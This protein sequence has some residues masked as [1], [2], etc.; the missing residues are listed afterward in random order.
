MKRPPVLFTRRCLAVDIGQRRVK[1]MLAERQGERMEVLHAI[2]IDLH[3]EGLL[4][5]E[6]A[7][8]HIARILDK[9][10]DYPVSIV[11]PQQIAPSHLI[12]LAPQ[13]KRGW[14]EMVEEETQ[15]L[16]GLSESALAY[17]VFRLRPFSRHQNPIWVTVSRENDLLSQIAR[18][19]PKLEISE[20]ASAAN[21]LAAAYIATHPPVNRVALVDLGGSSTTIV[22]LDRMQ[23]VFAA[24]LAIGSERFTEALATDLNLSFDEA[25]AVKKTSFL[26]ESSERNDAF[27][28]A[29]EEWRA[30]IE[31]I[32]NEWMRDQA[33]PS[34]RRFPI[35]LTG[36][37]SLQQGLSSHL[38]SVSDFPYIAWNESLGGVDA[39]TYAMVYG[40]ALAG[41]KVSPVSVS[42]LPKDIWA[43]KKRQRQVFAIN[44][45]ACL[46][47][48]GLFA[49]LFMDNAARRR[50]IHEKEGSLAELEHAQVIAGEVNVLIDERAS[51]YNYLEN[52]V[53][54]K[55]RARDLL[56]TLRL[57]SAARQ[58]HE[59]WFLLLADAQSYFY[60][61]TLQQQ[62]LVTVTRGQ[63]TGRRGQAVIGPSPS[64]EI[65]P[66]A[67]Q[68]GTD[69]FIVELAVLDEG[70]GTHVTLRNVVATFSQDPLYRNV[71]TLPHA[72]RRFIVNPN[73]TL[74]GRT[75]ALELNLIPSEMPMPD[76]SPTTVEYPAQ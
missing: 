21:A 43:R 15:K 46:L 40:A 69:S 59:I 57:M 19:D 22:L 29:I 3:E 50:V 7:N 4:T 27:V 26:F 12:P 49:I 33:E 51:E 65:R 39:R 31:R 9:F 75:F 37:G 1:L 18:L 41:V 55:R 73:L 45:L 71:D 74:P 42:L 60:G 25:E 44:A 20:V 17:G 48:A 23:P 6:E 70:R 2:T 11:L 68:P 35:V 72:E 16:T 53:Q 10:G 76:A 66:T 30:E 56:R 67:R 47:L 61:S 24:S 8:R 54:Q 13:G 5:I 36:G 28:K 34:D 63:P 14:R 52:M 32:L 38:N 64:P 58:N 62:D